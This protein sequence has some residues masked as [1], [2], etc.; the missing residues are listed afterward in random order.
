MVKDIT[1]L[2]I[3]H[4]RDESN[5]GILEVVTIFIDCLQLNHSPHPGMTGTITQLLSTFHFHLA[6]RIHS[7]LQVHH[8]SAVQMRN[9]NKSGNHHSVPNMQMTLGTDLHLTV[10]QTTLITSASQTDR[11]KEVTFMWSRVLV[12]GFVSK[13]H[14]L[15]ASREKPGGEANLT[16]WKSLYWTVGQGSRTHLCGIKPR[17]PV[18]RAGRP[19]HPSYSV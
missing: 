9:S 1:R 2:W 10:F 18:L 11:M 4:Y 15:L 13:Q 14:F 8:F 3:S 16:Q 5:N 19:C 7:Q 12:C 17:V 6:L